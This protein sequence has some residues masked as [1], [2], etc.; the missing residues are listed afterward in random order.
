MSRYAPHRWLMI[1]VKSPSAHYRIFGSWNGSYLEGESWRL[2]SGVSGVVERPD[3]FEVIGGS[4]SVYEIGKQ[5]YGS[6][7]YG[8][9]IVD[10]ILKQHLGIFGDDTA[11][12]LDE[13]EALKVLEDWTDA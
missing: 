10:G 9:S 5:S 2:N 11:R 12:I 6:T 4:G 1:Q 3:R 8:Q 13:A 7:A